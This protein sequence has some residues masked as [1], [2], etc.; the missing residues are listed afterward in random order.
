MMIIK[1]CELDID[2][3]CTLP[4]NEYVVLHTLGHVF[5]E[6]NGLTKMLY[7]ASNTNTTDEAHMHGSNTLVIMLIQILAGKLNEAWEYLRKSY[8]SSSFS[9][10]YQSR[11]DDKAK[12]AQSRL[13]RYFA[14]SN[15]IREIRDNFGFHYSKNEA[16]NQRFNNDYYPLIYLFGTHYSN[17][18]FFFS[19]TIQINNLLQ[20]LKAIDIKYTL[21]IL[22]REIF[23][24]VNMEQTLIDSIIT[25]IIK[26]NE[27][28]GLEVKVEDIEL[29]SLQNHKAFSIPWFTDISSMFE[30]K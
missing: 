20:L 18:L 7:W 29:K 22:I 5:N 26:K 10:I 24:I 3:L 6:L 19:E 12:N 14:K 1:R 21:E 16:N 2:K 25:E 8:Y 11:F 17:N 9:S 15:A 30:D 4:E 28:A 27:L 23:D 13:K